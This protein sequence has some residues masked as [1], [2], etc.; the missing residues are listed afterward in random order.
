M[1]IGLD[2]EIS[3]LKGI[4]IDGSQQVLG[5]ATADPTVSRP[6]ARPA[7]RRAEQAADDCITSAHSVMDR[8]AAQGVSATSAGARIAARTA[9]ARQLTPAEAL[10]MAF[11]EGYA[12]F[13]AAPTAI[14]GLI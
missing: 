4:L 1:Y 9:I 8:P 12:R 13:R 6:A 5:G 14:R 2:P 11:D 7:E 10:T 3:G